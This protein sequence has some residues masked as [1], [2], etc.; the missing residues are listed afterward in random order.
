MRLSR[1]LLEAVKAKARARGI[2]YT[3]YVRIVLEH[4]VTRAMFADEREV[5]DGRRPWRD[6][7]DAPRITGKWIAG[8][9]L[10]RERHSADRAAYEVIL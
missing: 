4:A 7:E 9:D 8:A 10:Y 2:P 1:S 6:P 5:E 3:R